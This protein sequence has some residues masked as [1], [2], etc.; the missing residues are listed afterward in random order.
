M[1]K[2]ECLL[3]AIDKINEEILCVFN[4]GYVMSFIRDTNRLEY[5]IITKGLS[6]VN[7]ICNDCLKVK[8]A[9][10]L[11]T[12]KTYMPNYIVCERLSKTPWDK[13]V[14]KI[15]KKIGKIQYSEPGILDVR[16]DLNVKKD[17]WSS[18]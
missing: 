11:E 4:G 18:Y 7:D 8:G 2:S 5:V 16:R 6:V 17:V 1:T 3:K 13:L 12:I 14:S 10:M 15:E 9:P